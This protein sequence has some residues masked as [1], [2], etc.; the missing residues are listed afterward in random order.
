MR[1]CVSLIVAAVILFLATTISMQ[2]AVPLTMTCQGRLLDSQ[3]QPISNGVHNMAFSIWDDSTAGS[4]LYFE[5]G[6][7]PT[8]DGRFSF[9]LGCVTP[10]M[11]IPDSGAVLWIQV[12]AEGEVLQPRL[13]LGSTPY[14][15]S[16]ASVKGDIITLPGRVGVSNAAGDRVVRLAT[17]DLSAGIAI[18]D[19]G[20]NGKLI[21]EGVDNAHVSRSM[22]FFDVFLELEMLNTDSIDATG[23]RQ[24]LSCDN[25]GSSGQDGVEMAARPSGASQVLYKKGL[26]AVNVRRAITSSTDDIEALH[27]IDADSDDDGVMDRSISSSCDATGAKHAINT[28]GTGATHNRTMSITSSTDESSASIGSD[29]DDDG[30]GIPESEAL[31]RLTPTTSSVAIKTKG[32]GA[33]ANRSIS[34]TCDDVSA[35][36]LLDCDDDGDG[37]AER[38][39]WEKVDNTGC[40]AVLELD[41]DHDRKPDNGSF[42]SVDASRSV[43][44][45]FFER[46]DKPSQSQIADTT[47]ELGARHAI[48]TKGTGT[49]GRVLSVT[50]STDAVSASTVCAADLD[51]DGVPESSLEQSCDL[52]S[53]VQRA[54]INNGGTGSSYNMRTR[55]NQL[56][57]VLLNHGL[58]SNTKVSSQCDQ[59]SAVHSLEADDLASGSSCQISYK[60][61]KVIGATL[62]NFVTSSGSAVFGQMADANSVESYIHKTDDGITRGVSMAAESNSTNLVIDSHNIQCRSAV[63]N[64]AGA[65][66]GSIEITAS[67]SRKASLDSD[68]DG[69]FA[70]KIGIG[71]DVPTHSI[72]V[73]GGAYCDGTNWMNASD[74]NLKENFSDVDGQELLS[75]IN[76]LTV[77]EWNYKNEN[78]NIKHIGPTAQDFQKSFGVGSDGK[79]ISTI[80]P[81]GIA[82]AAIKE[83][84]KQN[85]E[86]KDQNDE[87]KM[88]LDE[89]KEKV[90][91]LLLSK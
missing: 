43:L 54:Q 55:I 87:L 51:G 40:A 70:G 34:S 42:T 6:D 85:R 28:K 35:I 15:L 73:A 30:D 89:L 52:D 67:G 19:P 33:E 90:D 71:I 61:D 14:A 39:A 2:A 36:N 65:Y 83:L 37:I 29:I 62:G 9:C 46:G 27:R 45:T 18:G 80:D 68:G 24:R 22:S 38:S 31:Q 10:L 20:V 41:L 72:D 88:Q 57:Q 47:D 84:S 49:T 74:A 59:D 21:K 63:D 77:S 7:V 64:N 78:Q 56:E 3:D 5:T 60:A 53:V 1:R 82:L 11:Q 4:Q 91:G 50:S 16:S 25:L 69:F 32:T 81:S 26:N 8:Q 48:N 86:L 75:K 44:K 66:E 13:R 17:S 23:A 12:Q 79:S 76:N 58:L